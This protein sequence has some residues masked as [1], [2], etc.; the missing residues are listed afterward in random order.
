MSVNHYPSRLKAADLARREI[1]LIHV[2]RQKVGMDEDTYR[3]LL[4]DRFGVASSKELDWQQRKQLLEHFKTLG[5]KVIPS[6]KRPQARA[7]A[8]DA[9]S[10]KI[11]ELWLTLHSAGK[12]RNPSETALAAFVKRQTKVDAL[13]WLSTKQASAVIEELKKWL[14]R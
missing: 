12:V 4:L 8:G 2:A 10:T 1:Q 14:A 3:A 11:R 13:Q 7:L 5:F 9:Q 6:T